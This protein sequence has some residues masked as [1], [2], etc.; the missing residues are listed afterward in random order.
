MRTKLTII[1]PA[2]NEEDVIIA[3]LNDLERKLTIPCKILIVDDHSKDETAGLVKK[4]AR[5]NKNIGFVGNYGRNKGFSSTLKIGFEEAKTEFVLPVMADLCDSP[6][7]INKIYSM[8]NDGWD[9]I[10][11]S[12][13]MKGG[14]KKDGPKLQGFLSGFVCRSLH[15]LTGVPTHDVSNAFK[16]Y[17]KSLLKN[18]EIREGG[19]VEISMEITLQA[20]LKGARIAEIPTSWTGRK[21]GKSK[22]KIL[23][24]SPKYVKIYLWA[25]NNS[26]RK[27]LGLNYKSDYKY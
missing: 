22:F 18:V 3:T 16:V 17:R 15:F 5:R 20:Y 12:R 27:R 4:Y 8:L 11:G 24:R 19:G 14:K 9:I 1:I 2:H 6:R 23:Q 25:I 13:Y 26:T 10:C 21:M 7:T